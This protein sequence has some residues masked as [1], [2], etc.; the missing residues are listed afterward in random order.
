MKT[1]ISLPDDLFRQAEAF[2]RKRRVSRS[3]LYAEALSEFLD[4][5]RTSN[6]TQRLDA[7]YSKT[8]AKLDQ[9]LN[10]AQLKSLARDSW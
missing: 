5:R 2:A 1:A 8:P 4:R 7:I 3:R 9:T 10:S 6:I